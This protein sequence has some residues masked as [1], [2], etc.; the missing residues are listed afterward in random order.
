MEKKRSLIARLF[1]GMAGLVVVSTL[2]M[3]CNRH[4]G[5]ATHAG[6]GASS[7]NVLTIKGAGR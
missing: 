1:L 4:S 5:T 3:G 2:F 7:L 6:G